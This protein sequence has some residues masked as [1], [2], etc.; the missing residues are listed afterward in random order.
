[1]RRDPRIGITLGDP[2]GV[3]PEVVLKALAGSM[4][5]PEASVVLF[6]HVAAVE[7]AER[8]SGLRLDRSKIPIVEP[9]SLIFPSGAHAPAADNGAASFAYFEEGVRAVREDR[10]DALVTAP[11]SKA[12]WA[13][14][15]LPWRGHTEYLEHLHPGAIMAFW[16]D[17]LKLALFS[18]HLPL[19]EALRRVTRDGLRRFLISLAQTVE[20]RHPETT[21]FLVAGLN[22]H[23]GEGG[24]LGRE[25][26][27]TIGPAIEDARAEG[28]PARGP[29]PPDVVFRSALD[30]RET[31][32]VALTHDQGLIAFKLVAFESGINVTLGM[33][34]IRTSPD[35][36]TAFDIAGK[37]SADPRSMI[38]AI[39][40]A[41]AWGTSKK[42]S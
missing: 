30:R 12:A 38:A 32:A 40:Q 37:N 41:A 33:P 16:S 21:E 9:A 20:I 29:F 8:M 13:M 7:A 14:A 31:L 3:G 26:I 18:H 39:D 22:P 2:G 35:H 6:G 5:P 42:R 25:E 15:G 1:M 19:R 36:G 10:L 4:R 27:E 23:A 11:V 28:V 24:A 34:F 17:R